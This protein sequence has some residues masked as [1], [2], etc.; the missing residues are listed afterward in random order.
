MPY[1]VGTRLRKAARAVRDLHVQRSM[2]EN[3]D[4]QQMQQRDAVDAAPE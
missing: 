2:L 3:M 4:A 1:D